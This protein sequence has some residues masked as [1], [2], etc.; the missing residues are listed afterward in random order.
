MTDNDVATKNEIEAVLDPL[1]ISSL[2]LD[3]ATTPYPDVNQVIDKIIKLIDQIAAP[4]LDP[5]QLVKI[6][7]ILISMMRDAVRQVAPKIFQRT[8]HED[9]KITFTKRDLVFDT[10]IDALEDL[11]DKLEELEE[12]EE[13]ET[14]EEETEE[15]NEEKNDDAQDKDMNGDKEVKEAE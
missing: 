4:N 10:F 9:S 1:V 7:I 12:A 8:P 11:E 13:E 15:E 5:I 2:F 6:Q 3:L 14:E